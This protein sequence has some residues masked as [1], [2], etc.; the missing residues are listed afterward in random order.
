M[1][2]AIV[3]AAQG[4]ARTRPKLFGMCGCCLIVTSYVGLLYIWRNLPRHKPASIK[5][6]MVSVG[7]ACAVA[8]IPLAL[9]DGR[10]IQH[11]LG[12]SL[13]IFP[14]SVVKPMMLTCALFCGPLLYKLRDPELH[15]Q[16]MSA[17]DWIKRMV[18]RSW[19][20]GDLR[21][22][23]SEEGMEPFADHHLITWRNLVVSPITEEFCFRACM[24]P[25]L[26]EAFDLKAT[27]LITPLFF[28]AAHLHHLHD[29]V[30]FQRVPL[31]KAALIVTFQFAYTTVFGWFETLVFLRT[32]SILPPILIHSFCNWMGFPDVGRMKAQSGG[33]AALPLF[34]LAAGLTS[35]VIL[36][37]KWGA[38]DGLHHS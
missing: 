18:R 4:V 38:D 30:I 27:V 36:L 21:G 35:F 31:N 6:R 15:E 5:R 28:G 33:S 7:A 3:D 32:N 17:L 11:Q 23:V 13:R 20:D 9:R 19:L 25:L 26:I 12:L 8:W 2:S 1:L 22:A 16:V 29:L 34:L 37:R 24:A 10:D 14:G